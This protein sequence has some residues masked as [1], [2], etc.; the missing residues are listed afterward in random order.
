MLVCRR[1]YERALVAGRDGNVSVRVGL[2]RVLVTPS[3]MSKADVR[4]RDLVEVALDGA[5]VRRSGGARPPSSEILLHLATYRARPD[6]RAVVHAHP[7]AATGFAVAHEALDHGA[8][9]EM[10]YTVGRVPLV[11]YAMPGSRALAER[12]A[13]VLETHDAALLANHGAVTVGRTL[14][15]AHQRMESLEHGARI[16]L[17]ARR[18]GRVTRLTAEALGALEVE[19]A[20]ADRAIIAGRG[21]PRAARPG[22]G[23]GVR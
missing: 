20:A 19:R 23:K 8:L 22:K 14:E 7:P 10:A 1:L 9:A 6:V 3:G 13:R 4:E 5:P 2:D 18:A 12:V 15:A 21:G 16:L 11:P 17:A